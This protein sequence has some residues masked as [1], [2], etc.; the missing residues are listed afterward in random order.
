[1][2]L[3]IFSLLKTTKNTYASFGL[4]VR[5]EVEVFKKPNNKIG[6]VVYCKLNY[7]KQIVKIRIS[8]EKY[9][10]NT[11]L[12]IHL[13]G[14]HKKTKITE[15]NSNIPGQP[16]LPKPDTQEKIAPTKSISSLINKMADNM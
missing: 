2:I 3:Y 13:K 8:F 12:A 1:M 4:E 14:K 15:P 6:G 11:N 9:W 5:P 10:D 7:C 16:A